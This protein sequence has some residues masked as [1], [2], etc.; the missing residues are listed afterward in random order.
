[1]N[2]DINSIKSHEY[3]IVGAGISGLYSAYLLY[4]MFNITN[5]LVIEKSDRIG[6]RVHTM[7]DNNTNNSNT[8]FE[9]GASRIPLS[10][11]SIL[12]LIKDLG[13]EKTLSVTPITNKYY[14]EYDN[15][16]LKKTLLTHDTPYCK[17]IKEITE[18][19]KSNDP[20]VRKVA[21]N[22]SLYFFIEHFYGTET[23]ELVK[24]Q[25]GYTGDI[26]LQQ[27]Y[28][29]LEM[30]TNEFKSTGQFYKMDG[31]LVQII[32]KLVDK[33]TKA[34]IKII[35][36]HEL[37]D[38]N[39]NNKILDLKILNINTTINV[40]TNNIIFALTHNDL[41]KI[42]FLRIS[43]TFKLLN[44][45][46]MNKQLMRIYAFFPVNKSGGN[47]Y[48]N[49]DVNI[50]TNS[51][52]RQIKPTELEKGLLMISYSD[53]INSE[54]LNSL[55]ITDNELFKNEVMFH[56]RRLFPDKKIPDPLKF[57]YKYWETGTHIWKPS[58]DVVDVSK[59]MMMPF[60]SDK[61]SFDEIN[62]GIYIVGEVYAT[63]H[64]WMEGAIISVDN[65]MKHLTKYTFSELD[66]THVFGVRQ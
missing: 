21:E 14:Y 26:L 44:T 63:L 62:N 25:F 17:V 60:E 1:M 31:G 61:D 57:V 38:V 32:N 35:T 52:I 18:L 53:T 51:L 8:F 10:H 37:I 7:F 34:G 66:K 36:N 13:L 55:S 47:W 58:Y 42:P 15:S 65:L 9:L 41:L 23:A 2:M 4:K 59:K 49:I 54:V 56:L 11:N 50:V 40:N 3:V 29:A 22:Y 5:I 30:F 19:V 39:H 28:S 48:D 16:I 43:K 6:G 27:T 64:N 20:Y 45:S 24:D 12:N 46:V 33:I